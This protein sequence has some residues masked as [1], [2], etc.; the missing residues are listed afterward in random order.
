MASYRSQVQRSVVPVR[1]A[2][3]QISGTSAE[4]SG[5]PDLP[6]DDSRSPRRAPEPGTSRATRE[7]PAWDT[8]RQASV[9]AGLGDCGSG[10]DPAD[11]LDDDGESADT[12]RCRRLVASAQ[13]RQILRRELMHGWLRVQ[14]WITARY[15]PA[16]D[17]SQAK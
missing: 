14:G 2:A 6:S 5:W 13:F 11:C 12:A 15:P 16:P 7:R 1:D 8:S 4:S 3:A 9:R 17:A 10:W